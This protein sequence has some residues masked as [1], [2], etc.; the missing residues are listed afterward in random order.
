MATLH[1]PFT[2]RL[3]QHAL[4]CLVDHNFTG[5]DLFYRIKDCW[6]R[7]DEPHDLLLRPLVPGLSSKI[8]E[9][10]F[11]IFFDFEGFSEST[12]KPYFESMDAEDFFWF[13]ED[14]VEASRLSGFFESS[15]DL[16][17]SMKAEID[18]IDSLYDSMDD[19]KYWGRIKG[20]GRKKLL[21]LFKE[22]C[23]L[24]EPLS[25]MR[26]LYVPG[27]ADRILHDRELCSFIAQMVMDIG[28]DGETPEGLRTQWVDRER[29]PTTV[30]SILNTRDR[31]KCATC[32]IDI[33]NE[34]LAKAHIDHI[35]PITRGGC[36]DL[37]NLQ[38][39]CEKCNL[40]KSTKAKPVRSS[41][42]PYTRLK[43][44]RRTDT[45]IQRKRT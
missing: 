5:L 19:T 4:L 40:M 14:V 24:S 17:G 32:G 27:I 43:R 34:L 1:F 23:S 15:E 42:P 31:G 21:Q 39:L 3:Y 2:L 35:F 36:N 16:L 38:L 11:D 33:V 25:Q 26:S 7:R 20:R 10:C 41:I 9:W 6:K 22:F 13:F 29:W 12:N 18:K 28:F 37:V 8:G 44:R 30:K 45:P